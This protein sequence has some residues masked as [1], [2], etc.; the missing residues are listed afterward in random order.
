[1][2]NNTPFVLDLLCTILNTTFISDSPTWGTEIALEDAVFDASGAPPHH[3]HAFNGDKQWEYSR[4]LCALS[5]KG[6]SSPRPHVEEMYKQS[7]RMKKS[8]P[9]GY[10]HSKFVVTNEQKGEWEVDRP[11]E[12][13]SP[14]DHSS[15]SGSS[16]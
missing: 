14:T 1:M 8:N 11:L 16:L 6:A 9:V 5:G 12:S 2:R 13:K 3:Y 10:R 4:E 7:S 15:S